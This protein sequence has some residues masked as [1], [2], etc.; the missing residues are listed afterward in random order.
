[1]AEDEKIENAKLAKQRFENMDKYSLSI[2]N[3]SVWI[4]NLGELYWIL[5]CIFI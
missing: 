3:R 5:G 2:E 4:Q 1:M